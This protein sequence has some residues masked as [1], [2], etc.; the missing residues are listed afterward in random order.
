[1][2]SLELKA[3]VVRIIEELPVRFLGLALYLLRKFAERLPESRSSS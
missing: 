2:N 3:R 1:M